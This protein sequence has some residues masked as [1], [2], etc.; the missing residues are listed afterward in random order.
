[1]AKKWNMIV[2]VEKCDNCRLCFL[3]VKDEYTG[4]DFAGYSAAQPSLGHSWLDIKRKERGTY[5]IVRANFLP[6]MCNHCDNPPCLQNAKNGAIK[7]REDGIVLID[8]EKSKGQKQLVDS[9]PYGAISWNE[10]KEIPQAWT[11]D[12][13]LLDE[14]WKKTRAEQACPMDVF[15]TIKVDDKEMQ[16]I[17]A[18]EGLEVLEPQLGTKPRIYYK[19][20]HLITKCFVG[21]TI[22]QNLGSVEECASQVDVI[23]EKEGQTVGKTKTDIF[24]EFVFDG[25]EPNSG[26]YHLRAKSTSWQLTTEFNLGE[27]SKYLGV[28][29][30]QTK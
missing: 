8:P 12:A 30:L 20:L 29:E 22:T 27:E 2:D 15:R 14:G 1:M 24:G 13:H 6:V 7:K 11:F 21:G 25:L 16:Q 18:R 9:C 3:A 17:Q 26:I 4:N 5:P 10:E 23:L 28:L 19:N